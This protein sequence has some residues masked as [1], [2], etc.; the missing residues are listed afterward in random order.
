MLTIRRSRPEE[1]ERV[2]EIWRI[3]VDATMVSWLRRIAS[4]S[5]RWFAASCRRRSSRPEKGCPRSLLCGK[6]PLLCRWSKRRVVVCLTSD[7]RVTN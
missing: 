7:Y 3:A 1:G 6:R 5:T 2:I 4:P